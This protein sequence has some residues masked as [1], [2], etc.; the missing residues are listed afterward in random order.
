LGTS[1][2]I[3]FRIKYY[4]KIEGQEFIPGVN[5]PTPRLSTSVNIISNESK[6]FFTPG[7]NYYRI[8]KRDCPPRKIIPSVERDYPSPGEKTISNQRI[9]TP[10]S[11]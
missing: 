10:R 2:N 3:I 8:K 4:F 9:F 7:K 1:V 6:G 11:K 5:F